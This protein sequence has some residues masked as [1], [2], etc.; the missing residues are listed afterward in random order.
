MD[1]CQKIRT[2]FLHVITRFRLKKK[3]FYI[4][5]QG[6]NTILTPVTN[7]VDELQNLVGK[8]SRDLRIKRNQPKF[9][10]KRESM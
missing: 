3:D 10:D 4:Q 2:L 9:F 7:V 6:A 5:K 1:S 8:L